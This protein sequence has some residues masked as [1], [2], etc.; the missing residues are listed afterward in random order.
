MANA[1]SSLSYN[2][3]T[4]PFTLPY[5]ECKTADDTAAKTVS[6]PNF[7]LEV[8]ATIIVKFRYASGVASPTLNVNDTGAKSI[9][10]YGYTYD[11]SG[12]QL[13]AGAAASTG[14]STTGW[15]AGA[16]QMFT[17]DGTGW[18][19]DFWENSTYSNVSLGQGYCTCSTAVGTVAKTASLSSYSLSTGGIVAVKFTNGN[20]ASK[21][22]LNINSKGAKAIYYNGAA[23]TDTGLIQAGDIVTFIYSS[24]YH[25]ISIDKAGVIKTATTAASTLSHSGTFTAIT[26]LAIDGYNITPTTT[27]YTLPADNNTVYTHPTYTARTGKPTANQTPAFGGTATV[28]QITSDGTGHVT[29]ATD[30]TITIPSTL[31][32][33]T[34][35]AGLI[36]TS[37][38]VTSNSGY[39]ACPV[40][41]GVPY[42]KD[43]NTTYTLPAATSSAL[44]GVIVGSN[45][46]NSSGTISLT[47]ANVTAA[48]GYTPPT[49]DT[50]TTYTFASGDSNGQIKVTPSGGTAQNVSVTGLA[51]AAY[52]AVADSTSASAISTGTN[53]VTERDVYYGLPKINNSN[54]YTRSTTIYAPTAGGAS[55]YVLVGAGTTTA[56]TWKTLA[57]AGIAASGH[58]HDSTYLPLSGGTLTGNLIMDSG[59]RVIMPN[60]TA[61]S[62]YD[63]SGNRKAVAFLDTTGNL[64]FGAE[65]E[66]TTDN[67]HT[68]STFIN[69]SGTDKHVYLQHGGGSVWWEY[70]ST[71]DIYGVFRPGT[72]KMAALGR[73]GA[74]WF[75]VW[76]ATSSIQTSDEREKS[77]IMAISD[78]PVTYSRDG[79]GN[80]WEKLFNKLIPKTYTLNIESANHLNIGFVAQDVE[81]SMNELGLTTDDLALIDHSYWTDEETGEEKDSYGLAYEQFIALNTYMIQK[82]QDKI[83]TLEERIAQLEELVNSN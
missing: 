80:I 6:V 4:Y 40:I 74:M 42:Y 59:A 22:T 10:R 24:Y 34:G 12:T 51:A 30:R 41:S 36:K 49:S 18:V 65:G 19:R 54:S 75:K 64:H 77:D 13:T 66:N 1:I 68:G 33:G 60:N 53:L 23:L 52:K 82:Q 39:T 70:Y 14:T 44:G 29:A 61:Y 62:A 8:G 17:Y 46:T 56:P 15:R 28:S 16:I 73:S 5:G 43:T 47:K 55:G 3:N 9:Y 38:T 21:P 83:A 26:G 50:N 37:S 58:N 45:I 20:T 35:T 7:S 78:Y 32:N 63:S 57:N 27:T 81:K 72:N 2:N 25:I 79:S 11:D 71:S 31:S 76:A 48:L 67:A 69:A